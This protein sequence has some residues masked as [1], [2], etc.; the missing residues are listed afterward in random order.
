MVHFRLPLGFAGHWVP[1]IGSERDGFP[2]YQQQI[3]M[4]DPALDGP[5]RGKGD[6]D[7]M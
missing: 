2:M 4:T 1:L 3:N 6:W 5:G 7:L